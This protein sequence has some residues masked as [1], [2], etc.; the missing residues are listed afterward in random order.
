VPRDESHVSVGGMLS[1]GYGRLRRLR[2][3]VQSANFTEDKL[4]EIGS[5]W[6]KEQKRRSEVTESKSLD[7][8]IKEDR[9]ARNMY[10]V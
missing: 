8:D 5:K 3:E 7:G 4:T 10:R 9:S 2:K 6:P 1:F